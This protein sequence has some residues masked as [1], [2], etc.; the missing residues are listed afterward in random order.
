M[1]ILAFERLGEVMREGEE[2]GVRELGFWEGLGL[3][4]LCFGEKGGLDG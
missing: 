1:R 3:L 4:D 2:E